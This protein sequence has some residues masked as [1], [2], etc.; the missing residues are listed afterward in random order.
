MLMRRRQEGEYATHRRQRLYLGL[1][2]KK[3]SS[4]KIQGIKYPSFASTMWSEDFAFQFTSLLF[5]QPR[6]RNKSNSNLPWLLAFN[7]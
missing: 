4:R 5:W 1:R 2:R 3:E 7:S 6:R